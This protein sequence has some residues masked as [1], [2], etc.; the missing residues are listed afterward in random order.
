VP[1]LVVSCL[2][3]KF[4]F[5]SEYSCVCDPFSLKRLPRLNVIIAHDETFKVSQV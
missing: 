3:I 5:F 1:R 4:R 2:P